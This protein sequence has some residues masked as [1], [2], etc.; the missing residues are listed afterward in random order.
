MA[1]LEDT[2]MKKLELPEYMELSPDD[3]DVLKKLAD[4]LDGLTTQYKIDE[5]RLQEIERLLRQQ[6]SPGK[7]KRQ[8]IEKREKKVVNEREEEQERRDRILKQ[9]AERQFLED[10][11]QGSTDQ[12]RASITERF[13][14][15]ETKVDML[16]TISKNEEVS[17][18]SEGLVKELREMKVDMEKQLKG[19]KIMV[20]VS[21]WT[22]LLTL[23]RFRSVPDVAVLSSQ[24]FWAVC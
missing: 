3:K 6:S 17:G 1:N 18:L 11:V 23:S 5:A 2:F 22:T 21:I 19:V 13:G 16:R 24:P 8:E 12:I 10:V 7:G 9:E 15:L 4:S 14:A 20:G